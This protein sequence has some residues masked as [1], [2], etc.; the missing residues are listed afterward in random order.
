VEALSD[1]L[2]LEVEAFGVDAIVVEPGIIRAGFGE[3]AVRAIDAATRDSGSYAEF[4]RAVA[5]ATGGVHERGPP[6]MLGGP[7]G[8]V[9]SRIER[10]ISARRPRGRSAVTPS[11]R[12]LFAGRVALPGAGWDAMP[13]GRFPQP[14]KRPQTCPIVSSAPHHSG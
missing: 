14:R 13:H 2:R 9:A 6:A 1:A 7:P 11:A 4:G 10:A 3:T 8:A 12:V 5:A